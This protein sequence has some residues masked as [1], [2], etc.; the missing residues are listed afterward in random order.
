[1]AETAL[2]ALLARALETLGREASPETRARLEA[3]LRDL[4]AQLALEW[5]LGDGR[6]ESQTQL[7]EAWLSRLYDEIYLDEFPDALGLYS[8]FSFS[9]PRAQ[10]VAR[11]LSARGQARWRAAAVKELVTVLTAREAEARTAMSKA[12]GE[13]QRFELS[14]SKAGFNE[15]LVRYEAVVAGRNPK[16][17]PPR[18]LSSTPRLAWFNIAAVTLVL[19]VDSLKGSKR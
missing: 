14:I 4:A 9:L 17:S 8:R 6:P 16:P 15:L 7:A 2:T 5:L 18:R 13:T 1:V 11:L 12:R 10:Y 19:V 3:K